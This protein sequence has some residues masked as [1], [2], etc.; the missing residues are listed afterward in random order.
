MANATVGSRG[1]ITIPIKVRHALQ[2]DRGDRVEF[3][4]VA[5]G[6]FEFTAATQSVRAL[7]GL[8]GKPKRPT[9]GNYCS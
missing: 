6:R 9:A 4:A 5:P 2:L 7:K 8:F 1:R 3:V